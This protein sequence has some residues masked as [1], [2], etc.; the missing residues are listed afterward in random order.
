MDDIISSFKKLKK[1]TGGFTLA[2]VVVSIAILSIISVALLQMFTVSAGTNYS[3]YN[4]DKAKDLCVG[5]CENIKAD[6][7]S[8]SIFLSG[9]Y[10]TLDAPGVTTFTKYYDRQWNETA[11]GTGEYMLQIVTT[12]T[13]YAPQPISYYPPPA[14]EYEATVSL[15]ITLKR[16]P[17]D[18]DSCL[19]NFSG[20]SVSFDK[21]KIIYMDSAL[22][23]SKTALIPIHIKCNNIG[24]GVIL[25]ANVYNKV[26][27]L[28][29]NGNVYEAIADIYLCDIPET[30]DMSIVASEGISTENK[31]STL[32]Q[33]ISRYNTD[34]QVI[35]VNDS[36]ILAHYS[37]EKYW[38]EN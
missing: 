2:E 28:L 5:A 23:D 22:F 26:G 7:T 33:Q 38:V 11:T 32:Q 27:F 20:T 35:R 34:V 29:H 1:S 10:A 13:D 6:P 30:S 8:D 18:L 4:I 12:K 14:A 17:S 9:F 19:V 3:A 15:D 21:S 31:I 25:S 24:H 16:D 37:A 36:H